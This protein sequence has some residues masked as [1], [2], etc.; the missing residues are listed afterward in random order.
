MPSPAFV[1]G[2]ADGHEVDPFSQLSAH[3]LALMDQPESE[4]TIYDCEYCD[5]T[6]QGK[7]AR[8]IWRRH[9]SDKHK[10]PLST[11]PRRTRWDNG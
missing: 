5:K 7:H 8:S 2:E 6:Y 1:Q 10:I 11:Q 4:V 3:T 9:L